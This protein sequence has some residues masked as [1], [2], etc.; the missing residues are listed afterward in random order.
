MDGSV[1]FNRTFDEYAAGFGDLSGEFW[2]GNDLLN[3]LTSTIAMELRID[4]TDFDDVAVF[5]KYGKFA[6]GTPAKNYRLTVGG[7]FDGEGL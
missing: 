5:A 2:L 6:V 4:M 1:D 3:V 7:V